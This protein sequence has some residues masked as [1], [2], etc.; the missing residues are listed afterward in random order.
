MCCGHIKW[1][2]ERSSL[3]L[4]WQ[5]EFITPQ[6]LLLQSMLWSDKTTTYC[7][8]FIIK[9]E[10]SFIARFVFIFRLE[11]VLLVRMFDGNCVKFN[12]I[13]ELIIF[14]III[15]CLFKRRGNIL[16][17]GHQKCIRYA[18]GSGEHLPIGVLSPVWKLK[19]PI[20]GCN[21]LSRRGP[22]LV[23]H[24]IYKKNI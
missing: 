9:L 17:E 16:F 15:W 14:R 1:H 21:Q 7:L 23:C 19:L 11:I 18:V 3:L 24:Y 12:E 4:G 5:P 6:L 13:S 2:S 22:S 8:V 10:N 20:I